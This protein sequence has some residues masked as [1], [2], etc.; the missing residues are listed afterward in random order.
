MAL[1]TCAPI[2]RTDGQRKRPH[3]FRM[4][5]SFSRQVYAEAVHHQTMEIS[6]RRV[7]AN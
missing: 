4:V 6:R 1:G 7:G 2:L 3:V 5:L